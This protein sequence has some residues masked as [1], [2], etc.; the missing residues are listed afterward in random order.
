MASTSEPEDTVCYIVAGDNNAKRVINHH[1][2]QHSRVE[3]RHGPALRF[4]LTEAPLVARFC[5]APSSESEIYFP[6]A[7]PCYFDCSPHSGELL[8]HDTSSERTTKIYAGTDELLRGSPQCAIVLRD[9]PMSNLSKPTPRKYRL[10]VSDIEFYV[11]PPE[12]PDFPSAE[13]LDRRMKQFSQPSTDLLT[14]RDGKVRAVKERCLGKGAQGTVHYVVTTDVGLHLACKTVSLLDGKKIS[15]FLK[16]KAL[17]QLKCMKE[18]Y[19]TNPDSR[20][21]VP[22]LHHQFCE[23]EWSLDIFMPL[24]WCSLAAFIENKCFR[25]PHAIHIANHVL[26]NMSSALQC[27]SEHKP[28]IIHRDIK[29]DNI[30]YRDGNLF[31]TDF[32]LSKPVD[33][34]HSTVGTL[35]YSAP[36]MSIQSHK[37]SLDIFSLGMTLAVCLS[38]KTLSEINSIAIDKT[39]W[40]Q[41][42]QGVLQNNKAGFGKSTKNMLLERP[43]ARPTAATILDQTTAMLQPCTISCAEYCPKMPSRTALHVHDSLLTGSSMCTDGARTG[44]IVPMY[45]SANP[46]QNSPKV[47]SGSTTLTNTNTL[48]SP[49]S[50]AKVDLFCPP[51]QLVPIP[52]TTSIRSSYPPTETDASMSFSACGTESNTNRFRKRRHG[53]AYAPSDGTASSHPMELRSCKRR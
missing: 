22:W 27:L 13:M 33:N 7:S 41:F 44:S 21:I 14:P 11:Y 19:G 3:S 15:N 38:N 51:D 6:K 28:P 17:N 31:L 35:I 4:R 36:E 45:L 50:M 20:F 24:Y 23:K 9:D 10:I 18:A 47:N 39:K 1:K 25:G 48:L 42:A 2:N 49:E 34:N 29:P 26:H 32:G 12:A 30:L 37:P 43:E 16:D 46:P 53:S 5:R 8:L 52:D 40:M